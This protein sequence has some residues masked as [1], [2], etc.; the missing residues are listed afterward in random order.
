MC[1]TLCCLAPKNIC[2]AFHQTRS[3]RCCLHRA[4]PVLS[5]AGSPSDTFLSIR[6][7]GLGFVSD[8]RGYAH[9]TLGL[10]VGFAPDSRPSDTFFSERS[11]EARK[12]QERPG[13]AIEARRGQE[14]PGEARRGPQKPAEAKPGA[15]FI[16]SGPVQG[17]VEGS[18][19]QETPTEAR[20]S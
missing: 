2:K 12:S 16:H 3:C 10:G 19:E 14:G 13:E 17:L 1:P 5:T 6:D 11:G 15:V 4:L 9:D 8:S 7:Y 18:V 20:R